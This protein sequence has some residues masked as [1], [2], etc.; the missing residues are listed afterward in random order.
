[1]GAQRRVHPDVYWLHSSEDPPAQVTFFNKHG[2]NN[3]KG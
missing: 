2:Q 3:T 1:M